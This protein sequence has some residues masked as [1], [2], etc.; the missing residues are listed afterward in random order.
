M[1]RPN[2]SRS[3]KELCQ[4]LGSNVF[5]KSSEAYGQGSYCDL[6][7]VIDSPDCSFEGCNANNAYKMNKC[8]QNSPEDILLEGNDC[9]SC[10]N[11][12]PSIYY[13]ME[14]DCL[15]QNI[16]EDFNMF[17]PGGE[18]PM[19][20]SIIGPGGEPPM[21]P[22][23]IGP[24]GE[25]PMDPPIIGPGREPPMNPSIMGGCNGTEYGCCSDGITAASSAND[26]CK[27]R[28][29]PPFPPRPPIMRGCDGTEYGCCSDG[30]TAASS[31]NDPCKRRRPR[32]PFHPHHHPRHHRRFIDG[33]YINY[34]YPGYYKP[35]RDRCGCELIQL[36]NGQWVIHKGCTRPC[37]NKCRLNND[38]YGNRLFLDCDG[39]N[40]CMPKDN[41]NIGMC[42]KKC[43]TRLN[44][45]G[46]RN[47]CMPIDD[48]SKGVCIPDDELEFF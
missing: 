33:R 39:Y 8:C 45:C 37:R 7:D 48:T 40:E 14:N 1:K 24:G 44:N 26:R 25:P 4:A 34:Y 17:G 35:W 12:D 5:P 30:I 43:D 32:P 27:R 38:K 16:I 13:R 15:E 19:D 6:F 2:H 9:S 20:P 28:P 31:A 47:T 42:R 29:R 36:A 11:D 22:P 18:P 10:I 23:I 46:R 41:T 21:N 3:K